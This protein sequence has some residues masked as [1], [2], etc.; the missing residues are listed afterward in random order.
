MTTLKVVDEQ[1]S[2]PFVAPSSDAELVRDIQDRLS[3]ISL[4]NSSYCRHSRWE[5]GSSLE[6]FKGLAR[7]S[8]DTS[9][10]SE[11]S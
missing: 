1:L 8:S 7:Q 3:K 9:I 2:I 10:G 6:T 11:N 5:D 4:I